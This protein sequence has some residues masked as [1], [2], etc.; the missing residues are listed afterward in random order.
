MCKP[1]GCN[2]RS[3]LGQKITAKTNIHASLEDKQELVYIDPNNLKYNGFT[4]IYP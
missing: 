4:R 3:R 2:N 1:Y